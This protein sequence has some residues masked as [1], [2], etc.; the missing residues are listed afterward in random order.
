LAVDAAPVPI[1]VVHR[2][3]AV[4]LANP[5]A[6]RLFGLGPGDIGRLFQDLE[7]ASWPADLGS[8]VEQVQKEERPLIL[9]RIEWP[10]GP[11]GIDCFD[12]H[13]VPLAD[14]YDTTF[15]VALTFID[16]SLAGRLQQELQLMIEE[17]ET[18]N[19]EIQ[20][21]NEEL[22]TMNAELHSTNEELRTINDELRLRTGELDEANGLLES[23][24]I[25]LPGGVAVIDRDMRISVWN[26]P[27]A[28]LWG[29]RSDEARGQ[30]FL[31]LGIGLPVEE[32]RPTLKAILGG[33]SGGET[34]SLQA[35]NR[36]GKEFRCQVAMTPLL[37]EKRAIR[38]VVLLMDALDT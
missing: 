5:A 2:S 23:L 18:T 24:V 30:H 36:R 3:G 11:E 32:L 22:G 37:G 38:G 29:L 15:G 27:S 34:V 14:A 20:S 33:E 16:A 25:S 13:V 9:E 28:E 1:V 31:N 12:V 4:A 35:T 21:T 7:L 6:R 8:A 19:L 17:L 26:G 10:E